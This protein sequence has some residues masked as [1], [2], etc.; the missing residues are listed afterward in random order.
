MY[1]KF[2]FYYMFVVRQRE[3]IAK[4]CH[5]QRFLQ[6]FNSFETIFR[7]N[8]QN[9][10][11]YNSSPFF[12][13]KPLV[14]SCYRFLKRCSPKLEKYPDKIEKNKNK[15]NKSVI[16]I[17]NHMYKAH[18][19]FSAAARRKSRSGASR[20]SSSFANDGS[21]DFKFIKHCSTLAARW[22]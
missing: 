5:F 9:L 22:R 13:R 14:S 15:N 19:G 7:K 2:I 6:F 18:S 17:L 12:L 20:R 3:K 16:T 8:K 4:N 11:I 10:F 1:I 21:V